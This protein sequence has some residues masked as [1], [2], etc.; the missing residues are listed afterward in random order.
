MVKLNSLYA[1]KSAT[2]HS[3]YA[4]HAMRVPPF[5]DLTF[6]PLFCPLGTPPHLLRFI[7][8]SLLTHPY[9]H[10]ILPSWLVLLFYATTLAV[11][12]TVCIYFTARRKTSRPRLPLFPF[13]RMGDYHPLRARTLSRSLSRSWPVP[14][15][16]KPSRDNH[17]DTKCVSARKSC[18]RTPHWH[19]GIARFT[20][21]M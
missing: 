20:V 14:A 16:Y 7:G 15:G 4:R 2:Y 1:S 13:C 6:H 21:F 10:P 5:S 19:L 12:Y 3:V 9:P 8:L 17:R 11:I 18:V